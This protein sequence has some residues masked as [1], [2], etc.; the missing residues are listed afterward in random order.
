MACQSFLVDLFDVNG[1]H[2]GRLR[3]QVLEPTETAVHNAGATLSYS[4]LQQRCDSSPWSSI[5][6]KHLEQ[7]HDLIRIQDFTWTS[8]GTRRRGQLA[9]FQVPS[10]TELKQCS[11]CS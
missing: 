5:L 4:Q 8:L 11:I 10:T 7:V 1:R 3:S 2:T 9:L 6:T